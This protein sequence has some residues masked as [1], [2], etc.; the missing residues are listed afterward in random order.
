MHYRRKHGKSDLG[1][2][3]AIVR[4]ILKVLMLIRYIKLKLKHVASRHK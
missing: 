4:K 1:T 3:L 2:V